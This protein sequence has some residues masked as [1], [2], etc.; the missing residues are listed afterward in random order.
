VRLTYR[1]K[2]RGSAAGEVRITT[3]DPDPQERTL[4][5]ILSGKGR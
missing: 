5:V 4:R 3:D 2:K 1:P